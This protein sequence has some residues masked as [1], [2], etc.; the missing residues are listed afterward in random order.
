M[1]DLTGKTLA[2]G[3]PNL[4]TIGATT[5]DNPT[6]GTL[7]NG[8]GNNLT[9]V[10]VDGDI[11]IADKIIHSGDTNTAIRFPSID[12]VTVETAGSEAMRIDSLGNV[13]I[14]ITNPIN[15]LDVYG[16]RSINNRFTEDIRDVEISSGANT[17][18]TYEFNIANQNALIYLDLSLSF[19]G[20]SSNPS[21]YRGGSY[22]FRAGCLT[23]NEVNLSALT[24][25][26]SDGITTPTVADS[27]STNRRF[28]ITVANPLSGINAKMTARVASLTNKGYLTRIS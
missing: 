5:N 24:T 4:V 11:T 16:T 8:K 26:F 9:S 3:Y 27:G 28:T 17:V 15:A 12:T 14:G 21:N 7:E 25:L 23:T 10:T 2:N 20:T 22:I 6:S 13:G 18:F 1:A 19:S